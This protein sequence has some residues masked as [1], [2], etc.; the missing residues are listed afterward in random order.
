MKAAL[1]VFGLPYHTDPNGTDI[2]F[3]KARGEN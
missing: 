1:A 2:E 3:L